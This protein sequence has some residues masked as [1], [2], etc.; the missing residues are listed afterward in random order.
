MEKHCNDSFG[1]AVDYVRKPFKVAYILLVMV[2]AF[3][4]II[5]VFVWLV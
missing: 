2:Y 5:A 4:Y 3:A 1:A